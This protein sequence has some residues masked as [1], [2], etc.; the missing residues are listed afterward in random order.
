M[1]D[2]LSRNGTSLRPSSLGTDGRAPA[3]MKMRSAE[4]VRCTPSLMRTLTFLG[5]VKRASPKIRSRLAVFSRRFWLPLR[6]LS[7]M[8]RLRWRTRCISMRMSPVWTPYSL[9]RRARY[10]TR[11][12]ASIVFVG[13][14]PSLTQVPP[15]WLRSTSA[16]RRPASANALQRGVPPCP[17]PITIDW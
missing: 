15:M 9:P 4:R 1:I 12:L 16:V 6:K 17:E 3:L 8:S 2:L 13:V 10:A 14:Q 5:P 11:P 7:T